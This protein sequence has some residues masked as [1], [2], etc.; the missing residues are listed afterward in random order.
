[1]L[2]CGGF[3]IQPM[4]PGRLPVWLDWTHR[5]LRLKC[6]GQRQLFGFVAALPQPD[7]RCP[8]AGFCTHRAC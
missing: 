3:V 5:F 2:V 8:T 4:S 6:A 1:M 7:N